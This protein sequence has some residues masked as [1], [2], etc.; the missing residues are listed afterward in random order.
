M[1]ISDEVGRIVDMA[2]RLSAVEKNELVKLIMADTRKDVNILKAR[3]SPLQSG[4]GI[5]AEYKP[6]PTET[7]IREMRKEIF[8]QFPREDI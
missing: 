3:K 7:D 1:E 8:N 5:C 2:F 4:Y 6:A